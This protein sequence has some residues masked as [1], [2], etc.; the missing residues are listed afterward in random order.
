VAITAI[1]SAMTALVSGTRYS[2]SFG[3]ASKVT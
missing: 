2:N 1:A 3:V